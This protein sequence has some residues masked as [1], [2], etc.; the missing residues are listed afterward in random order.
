MK[1]LSGKWVFKLKWDQD[2]NII[3]FKARYVVKGFIQRFRVNYTDTYA[4]VANIDI[5]Q[6][7]LAMT[8]FYD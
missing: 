5:I 6:L 1:V 7:L 4:N 8:C 2:G 3:K